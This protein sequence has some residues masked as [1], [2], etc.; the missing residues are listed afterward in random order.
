VLGRIIGLLIS[1]LLIITALH[2]VQKSVDRPSEE[3]ISNR[4]LFPLK[5]TSPTPPEFK[6]PEIETANVST[7]LGIMH[8]VDSQTL[9][10]RFS[11]KALIKTTK[12][13][14]IDPKTLEFYES[15]SFQIVDGL[16]SRSLVTS[17][18]ING[19]ARPATLT[20]G[21]DNV[22]MTL[23]YSDGVLAGEG[24]M[25]SIVLNKTKEFIDIV[26]EPEYQIPSHK[27]PHTEITPLCLNC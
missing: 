14:Y 9:E 8:I 10:I 6:V 1:V 12:L 21:R 20:V 11:N 4:V 22:Y 25:S 18:L 2:S 7:L 23:P 13:E 3:D 24:T 19:I 27:E 15:D 16:S 5:P 26:K 17:V